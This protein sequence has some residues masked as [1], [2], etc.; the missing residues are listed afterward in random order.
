VLVGVE[1]RCVLELGHRHAS[2]CSRSGLDMS[3]AQLDDC[4]K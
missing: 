3:F 1:D 4:V 2:R